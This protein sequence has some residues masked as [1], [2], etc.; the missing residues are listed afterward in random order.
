METSY[1]FFYFC[2][3]DCIYTHHT[4]TL[5]NQ[6]L[7]LQ[8]GNIVYWNTDVAGPSYPAPPL[9]LDC[10]FGIVWNAWFVWSFL[11]NNSRIMEIWGNRLTGVQVS[12]ITFYVR[13]CC[14]YS[15]SNWQMLD[16]VDY[17]VTDVFSHKSTCPKLLQPTVYL[18]F[19]MRQM[20][21]INNFI[22]VE[23]FLKT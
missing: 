23:V 13:V 14:T 7:H 15:I 16:K 12:H 11:L 5:L 19:K 18:K 4:H 1:F 8:S 10:T 9:Q 21:E 6:D 20:I 3:Y 22:S 2:T 17:E